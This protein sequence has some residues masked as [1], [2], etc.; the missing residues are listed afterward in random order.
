MGL[1]LSTS[2]AE[3]PPCFPLGLQA[4]RVEN[5]LNVPPRI[6]PTSSPT[7]SP[8]LP[9]WESAPP[10]RPLPSP[11][12]MCRTA[13]PHPVPAEEGAPLLLL[14][15]LTGSPFL[16][17][18]Q[19][20]VGDEASPPLVSGGP[21]RITLH[22]PG[23][24]PQPSPLVRQWAELCGSS[25]GAGGPIVTS[26]PS[27]PGRGSGSVGRGGVRRWQPWEEAAREAEKSKPGPIPRLGPQPPILQRTERLDR[28][29]GPLSPN[30]G[31]VR[32]EQSGRPGPGRER[33][34][35]TAGSRNLRCGEGRRLGPSLLLAPRGGG[36][37]G[38]GGLGRWG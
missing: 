12:G 22:R 30:R 23:T 25:P 27:G 38:I 35:G 14:R 7:G 20:P 34:R 13:L 19:I 17:R 9:S 26:F 37:R 4:A 2:P 21:R 18:A 5:L 6:R 36:G 33:A 16:S 31:P 11:N 28:P 10:H 29:D 1:A 15:T 8:P 3:R 24:G 32:L